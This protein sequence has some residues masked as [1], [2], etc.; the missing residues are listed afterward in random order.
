MNLSQ[1]KEKI[2]DLIKVAYKG[3]L[4]LP[5]FQR[6]FVWQRSDIEELIKSLLE[7]V[8]IGTFLI[9]DTNHRVIPFKPIFIQGVQKVNPEVKQ[10]PKKLLLDGQQRLTA[11][12]YAIYSPNLPLR[13]TETPYKFFIDL[14]KLAKDDVENAVFS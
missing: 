12:F 1:S 3:E 10:N 11:I 2:L 5:D 13:Y 9:L 4:V 6:N 7:N 14:E 8:F